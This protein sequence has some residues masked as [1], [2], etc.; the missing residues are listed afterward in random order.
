[1]LDGREILVWKFRTMTPE[2]HDSGVS[3][4]YKEGRITP[5]GRVLR[6][7]RLDELPQLFN[8]LRGD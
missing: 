3:S 8:I 6:R 4:G 2:C 5:L 7:T 1:M